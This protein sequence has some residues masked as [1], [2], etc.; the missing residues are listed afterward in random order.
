MKKE[1]DKDTGPKKPKINIDEFPEIADCTA[2]LEDFVYDTE[3]A[4]WWHIK[5]SKL[6]VKESVQKKIPRAYYAHDPVFDVNGQ[7]RLKPNGTPLTKAVLPNVSIGRDDN[8]AVSDST[9]WPGMPKIIKNHSIIGHCVTPDPKSG[10]H[11]F[12]TYIEPPSAPEGKAELATL[13]IDH[14]KA[15]WP[16]EVEHEFFFNFMAHMFQ[17]PQEK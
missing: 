5:T 4:K 14:V 7:P 9:W 17:R 1:K 11:L 16:E 6:Y 13:W 3:Q 10:N 12:N 15:L 2:T 8:R